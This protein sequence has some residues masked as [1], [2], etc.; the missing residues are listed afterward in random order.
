MEQLAQYDL[1]LIDVENQQYAPQR[2]A[3]LRVLNPDITILA[4]ISL[5]DIRP[6]AADLEDGTFR[7]K[8]GNR[9]NENPSWILRDRNGDK[10]QWWPTYNIFNLTDI[11]GSDVDTKFNEVFPNLI[12][13]EI[14]SSGLW[15]GV[16]LDNVWED[17]SWIGETVDLDQ[18]GQ[19]E[20]ASEYDQAWN[21]GVQEVLRRI[22]N[23]TDADW[24]ITGN[25]GVGYADQL[26]GVA[27][28]NFP[29]TKYGSW[30]PSLR[31]YL[32]IDNENGLA[33]INSNDNDGGNSANYQDFRFGLASALLGEG[34]YGFDSGP[35]TH[36]E[37]FF[38]DEY[39][40]ALGDPVSGPFNTLD[41]AHPTELA[42]GLWRRDF[43]NG[44]VL[45]NST[46]SSRQYILEEGFEKV[47]GEQDPAVNSGKL[48]GS[49]TI[50]ANDGI[51]LLNR[52]SSITGDTFINGASA[53][54]F[55]D[56][57][58]EVR[59]SFFSYDGAFPGGT[60]IIRLPDVGKIV[61]AGDTYIDV[62]DTSNKQLAHFAPYGTSFSGG[63]DISV[64]RINGK[65]KAYRIVTGTESQ[66][67]QVRIFSLK[68]ILKHPGCFP[69][70]EGF[71]GGVHVAVGNVDG[72]GKMEIVTAAGVGGGPHVQV[73]DNQC[74]LK[75]PGFFAF[76]SSARYGLNIAVGD[77]NGDGQDEIVTAPGVGGGPQVRIYTY[78]AKLISAGFFAYDQADR[79]GLHL[80]TSDITGD[81]I[82]EII[83]NSFSVFNSF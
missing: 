51:L 19:A 60:Q 18:D 55:D 41:S 43:E 74:R 45:L 83:V 58:E 13:S 3:Q 73:L 38:Y 12:A 7:G 27:F 34:Y 80:A 40:V 77:V 47:K 10:V 50:P 44:I 70:P 82:E 6:D 75:Y 52:L 33:I 66:G 78:R 81:G 63:V 62:Y 20:S 28:E 56:Q 39:E 17:I 29:N 61:V 25:G 69:Y 11:T 67:P 30:I 54:V 72:K 42:E 71:R 46:S 57:G 79:S 35:Q 4:Y 8:L 23:Q 48:I 49:V 5:S 53:K 68:G 21:D 36:H 32:F 31:E 64:G 16:F 37:L 26:D 65:K 1:V 22:R 2:L 59:N 14:Y 76:D 9:M 15:D 24:I